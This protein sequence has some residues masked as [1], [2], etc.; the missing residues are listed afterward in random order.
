M[1]A[2]LKVVLVAVLAAALVACGATYTAFGGPD[3]DAPDAD[4]PA[5]GTDATED[6]E[7]T[8]EVFCGG[9]VTFDPSAGLLTAEYE[10]EWTVFDLLESCYVKV[11]GRW[12]EYAGYTETASSLYLSPGIYT[13]TAY[14]CEF[15]VVVPGEL[16]YTAE[17]VYYDYCAQKSWAVAIE[18]MIDA[19]TLYEQRADSIEYNDDG[20]NTSFANLPELVQVTP[21]IYAI[22]EAL[23]AE[24]VR[25][26]GDVDDRQGYA[27]FLAS[28]AQLAISYPSRMSGEA[29]D[30]VPYGRAEYWARPLETLCKQ[31]GDCEDKS[32]LLC[33]I[34]VA[35]GYQTAM[36][37]IAGHVFAGVAIDG[38][39]E[40]S[41]EQ[42][43]EV[44]STN[45]YKLACA[46]PVSGTCE[47][48]LAET[49]FY[50]VETTKK[51]MYVG[52]L[53][54]GTTWFG[55]KTSWGTSGFYPV[56]ARSRRRVGDPPR[57]VGLG[58]ADR[59]LVPHVEGHEVPG[60]DRPD[61]GGFLDLCRLGVR[62]L[63]EHDYPEVH[64]DRQLG[65]HAID[66][67]HR[68]VRTQME[69]YVLPEGCRD[70]QEQDPRS[71]VL[72]GD[73]VGVLRVADVGQDPVSRVHHEPR[74]RGV[75]VDCPADADAHPVDVEDVARMEHA[76]AFGEP[77]VVQGNPGAQLP[78]PLDDGFGAVEA[79]APH[80][81]APG[82]PLDDAGGVRVVVGVA[83]RHEDGVRPG[84]VVADSLHLDQRAG[85]RVY[86]EEP[87]AVL[88]QE[89]SRRAGLIHGGVPPA[90]GPQEGHVEV[91]VR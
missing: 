34:Y 67:R 37:G 70:R 72:V 48:D 89:P 68:V 3:T 29:E 20:K 90:A 26:G 4:D 10:T 35:A 87:S 88:H 61:S 66:E 49:V 38:F 19:Q 14:G 30:Y 17:W 5:S 81:S 60:G 77:S 1:G 44:D 84:E 42:R 6:T 91:H 16:S 32:A 27:D 82:H 57:F 62:S 69:R 83:V 45:N 39:E 25:I 21:E 22:E 51:Q 58:V 56:T 85:A 50:A 28:F 53:T 23:G 18:Y 74:V 59:Q 63:P 36:G 75:A 54:S 31:V 64:E 52:Y 2:G 11:N 8:T 12:T 9:L 65:L 7:D 40:I 79:A 24:F 71:G 76:D 80:P 55:M 41:E 86:V 13:V 43:T 78:R 15:E 47:G 33:A 73:L 46:V